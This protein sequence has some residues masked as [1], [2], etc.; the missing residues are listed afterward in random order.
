M[1]IV[2]RALAI[3]CLLA[4]TICDA[5]AAAERLIEKAKPAVVVITQRARDGSV[6]GVGSGFFISRA[7]LVATSLHVIGEGRPI[8]IRT[9]SG[10]RHTVTEIHAWDRKTDLAIL[11]VAAT[12]TPLLKLG[13]TKELKQGAP[14]VAIGNPRGLAHSVVEG[15]VSA[16]REFESGRMIQLAIPIE[17]G[18]SG[19]P[20]LDA[21]G[22]VVGILEMKS[23][24][25]ENL[26]FAT[27]VDALHA[28]LEKPNPVPIN[29]WIK[30]GALDPRKWKPHYGAS[31]T[32]RAGQIRV[33]GAGSGF[34]GRS[35][36]FHQPAPPELP[37]ELSVTVKLDDESG[38]AGLIFCA[39]GADRH[40]GFYPTGG[41]LR[42]TRFEGPEVFS[43]TIL[44]TTPSDAYRAG[45]WNTLRVRVDAKS[46]RC[47]VNG[48]LAI[49]SNDTA[50][51]DGAVGLA[52]FRDTEAVFK[53]F[54]IGRAGDRAN[55][56]TKRAEL[57]TKAREKEKEAAQLRRDADA[58]HLAE[59][60]TNLTTELN[61]PAAETDLFLAALWVA[62]LDN[63][64]LDIASY[65]D[66]LNAMADELKKNLPADASQP[67]KLD[68]LIK[69]LFKEN[70]FH[71]SRADYYNRS[72]SY[73]NEV[74]D[75]RE[76][77]P[78]T[79]SIL[80][81]ELAR[82][83]DLRDISGAPLPGHFMVQHMPAN[84]SARF[85]DVF[86]GGRTGDRS[87]AYEWASARSEV[88]I[89]NEH[90]RP[91]DNREIIV[92]MLRN[93]IGLAKPGDDPAQTLRYLELLLAIAPEEPI[94]RWKRGILR[95]QT[96]D[97]A[98]AR[99][100]LEW[101]LNKQPAGVDLERVE[102]VLRSLR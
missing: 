45:D 40:Y 10:E 56:A 99:S 13:D 37:F 36:L 15:V 43:W 32:R 22:R 93:L 75:D 46:I 68:A 77:I 21:E 71:G 25:T 2:P 51:R 60:Q 42:L 91:A 89:L 17:P 72:N 23:A 78:L 59:V 9:A 6:E 87:Q 85:I 35:L 24:V 26:G 70:G 63:P 92:R 18:N 20:L 53:T 101:L 33:T 74:I 61:K 38:A 8:E 41:Q 97:L 65:R 11:R 98:G 54:E 73:I 69:F 66:E 94:E 29:N 50:F 90:F 5:E 84:G 86:E 100:D 12:N 14:V 7:G 48:E 81:M 79:L 57:L 30:L 55:D 82:R 52:K 64:D 67:Q 102:E 44:Q 34:G 19:G 39:D 76:G 80:F 4:A 3:L 47:Y 1:S 31:W 16:F 88:P 95:W 27:P 58:A 83:I 96:R 62:R 49:E 28:L